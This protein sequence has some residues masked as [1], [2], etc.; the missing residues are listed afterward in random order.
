MKIPF[1]VERF[2][3]VLSRYNESVWPMPIVLIILA[4]AIVVLLVGGPSSGGI[5]SPLKESGT[6]CSF[7]YLKNLPIKTHFNSPSPNVWFEKIEERKR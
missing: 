1:T 6:D 3:E 4:I 2:F 5:S 7:V